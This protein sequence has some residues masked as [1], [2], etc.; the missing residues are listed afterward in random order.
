MHRVILLIMLAL[1]VASCQTSGGD[2]YA[3]PHYAASAAR[4]GRG[5]GDGH[6]DNR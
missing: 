1:A 2:P 4:L 5:G 6:G 3:D